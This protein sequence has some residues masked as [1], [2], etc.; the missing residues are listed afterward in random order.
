M[1]G[2]NAHEI[3]V[4]FGISEVG[5]GWLIMLAKRKHLITVGKKVIYRE[6]PFTSPAI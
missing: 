2:C 4:W 5:A 3:A 6:A 1:A